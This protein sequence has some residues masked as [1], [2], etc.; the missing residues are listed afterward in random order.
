MGQANVHVDSSDEL[1]RVAVPSQ[2]RVSLHAWRLPR[3]FKT[4]SESCRRCSTPQ[5]ATRRTTHTYMPT[6]ATSTPTRATH[7]KNNHAPAA[8]WRRAATALCVPVS[9]MT[10]WQAA[11]ATGSVLPAQDSRR[12]TGLR[13][14]GKASPNRR[15]GGQALELRQY[16]LSIRTCKKKATHTYI[17]LNEHK[18]KNVQTPA[19]MHICKHVHFSKY[20]NK[21]SFALT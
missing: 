5:H 9:K 6:L 10:V 16:N 14:P 18:H 3:R 19:H 13:G 12:R 15:A 1:S 8:A 17:Y 7:H 4:A 20:E 21:T 2:L 11:Q